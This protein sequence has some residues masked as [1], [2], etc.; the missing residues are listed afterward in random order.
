MAGGAGN[1]TYV[2]DNTGDIVTEN[3]NE[4]T[5]LVQ[6][7]VNYT[8]SGNASGVENLT[9]T[10]IAAINATGNALANTLTGNAANN[11]LDGGAGVDTL[12]G[13]AGDDTYIVDLTAA[14]ALQDTITEIVLATNNDTVQLRG[15]STNVAA[16]TLTVAAN[17]EHM[18]ASQTGTSLLNLTGNT[19]NNRLTGNAAN[20]TINGGTGADTMAGGAGNDTYVVDNTGDIVTENLNEGTD[21]VQ[22][23]VT[24]TLSG[25]A[26]GV[27]NLTLT[28]I[29]AAINA[30][31]NALNN[32]IIG[33]AGNNILNGGL[34]ADTLTGGAGNDM[35][36][37]NATDYQSF[38]DTITDFK[39]SGTDRLQLSKAVFGQLQSG[40]PNA[41]GVALTPADF[42][43]GT[44]ITASSNTGQHL[45][46]DNDSGALYYD[47]DG[48]GANDAYQIML[49]G[50]ATGLL[51]TDILV[52][53]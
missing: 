6:S 24:Y 12:V 32:T 9:L 38:Y 31:G 8:L 29:I 13:G 35:F 47:A 42:I 28:G 15:N 51:S 27:E 30:T 43:S 44:D 39:V 22:S 25:N 20:N 36:V 4:G 52:I 37:L 7:S 26:S 41:T 53:L 18:D 10:G 46:Y 50:T 17:L 14:G 45:L 34:G 2:V 23:S 5:D 3:L 16:V 33:N 49:I 19:A 40:T 48:I 1:D 11:I 21:L